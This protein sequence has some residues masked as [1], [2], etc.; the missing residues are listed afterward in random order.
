MATM[1]P[2]HAP[3]VWRSGKATVR[4]LNISWLLKISNS[5]RWPGRIM[6]LAR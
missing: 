4:P 6:K 2:V 1:R 5:T 3:M